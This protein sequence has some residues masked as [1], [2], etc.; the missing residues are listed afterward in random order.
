MKIYEEIKT[1][2]VYAL[3]LGCHN[4]C[5]KNGV[6]YLA[7]KSVLLENVKTGTQKDMLS[8]TFIMNFKEIK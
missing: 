2:K 7:S 8:K 6:H 3:V 4:D 5:V 1:G